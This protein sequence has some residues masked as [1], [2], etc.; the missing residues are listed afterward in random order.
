[1]RQWLDGRRPGL[2]PCVS[3]AAQSHP[4]DP[5]ETQQPGRHFDPCCGTKADI[6][7]GKNIFSP[8]VGWMMASLIRFASHR[9][10]SDASGAAPRACRSSKSTLAASSAS[11]TRSVEGETISR[12]CERRPEY[13]FW[14]YRVPEGSKGGVEEAIEASGTPVEAVGRRRDRN[15]RRQTDRQTT[16]R[17]LYKH[18]NNSPPL[19]CSDWTRKAT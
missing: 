6:R 13:V 14:S 15:L 1:M 10:A 9:S 4:A 8:V 7:P 19:L 17:R 12:K 16:E 18:A 5:E 3:E 11:P 2:S